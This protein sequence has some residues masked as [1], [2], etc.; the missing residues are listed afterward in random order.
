M[1]P[2]SG[3][4]GPEWAGG[5][6]LP[7]WMAMM[8]I[9]GFLS[10]VLFSV[11]AGSLGASTLLGQN[12]PLD[13]GRF[14]LFL[15]DQSAG[16]ESFS[17][18]RSGSGDD[19][20]V[21]ATAQIQMNL[22][23]GAIELRPALQARGP[24]LAISAYQVKVSGSSEEEIYVTLGDR[25][26]HTKVVSAR[27]EQEREYRAQTGTLLLDR[28]V[29][30]QFYFLQPLLDRG[31]GTVPVII[32]RQGRQV[33]LRLTPT[34][35]ESLQIG[36]QTVQAH[37]FQLEGGGEEWLLWFDAQGRVLRV[38]EPGSGYRA[39]REAVPG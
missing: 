1:G 21:I 31:E 33:Q 16:D 15:N 18:R 3:A 38:E 29:A 14:I 36:G 11:T 30:H 9:H 26:F 4:D 20:Q 22:P 23:E 37:R 35:T 12:V 39:I 2:G 6:F 10:F 28:G 17:I 32:P 19:A 25:R 5:A 27:G 24:E 8:R 7:D 34:G 13:E